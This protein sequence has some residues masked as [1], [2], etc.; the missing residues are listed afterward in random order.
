MHNKCRLFTLLAAL[1]LSPAL[2]HGA[3]GVQPAA[4]ITDPGKLAKTS[5]VHGNR[6]RIEQ[7]GR[8]GLAFEV[9]I[10]G[11]AEPRV[12]GAILET[13]GF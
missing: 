13:A 10:D 8:S 2:S 7:D 6:S 9:G 3:D 1:A 4:L 11:I 5:A 12:D